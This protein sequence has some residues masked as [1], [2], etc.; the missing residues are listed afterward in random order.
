MH[1]F[2][3]KCSPTLPTFLGGFGL[4][5]LAFL[6]TFWV[7]FLCSLLSVASTGNTYM[8]FRREIE[9]A[10][11]NFKSQIT[12]HK[13]RNGDRCLHAVSSTGAFFRRAGVALRARLALAPT[14]HP[15]PRLK[16]RKKKMTPVLQTMKIVT[17]E[18]LEG[19]GVLR[20]TGSMIFLNVLKKG[21]ELEPFSSESLKMGMDSGD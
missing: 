13:L 2:L 15:P 21:I 18:G 19:G 9:T 10:D 7:F 8:K 1:V 11:Y 3:S 5:R 14:P 16:K 17:R 12:S 20:Y 6:E 4:L